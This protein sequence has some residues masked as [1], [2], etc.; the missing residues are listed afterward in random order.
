MEIEKVPTLLRYPGG[1]TRAIKFLRDYIPKNTKEICSPFFG[2][3]AFELYLI[4]QGFSVYGY[5]SF[6]PLIKFWKAVLS[7]PRDLSNRVR[8]YYPLSKEKFYKLQKEIL[9]TEDSL[10]VAAIFFVL[11]RSS[12]SGMTLSGGMSPNHP[13]FTDNSIKKLINLKLI[14]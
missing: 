5:D 13:R 2:G 3:G 11:N 4:N 9:V 8:S 1:K 10:E 12:Y 7:D 6:S 14:D